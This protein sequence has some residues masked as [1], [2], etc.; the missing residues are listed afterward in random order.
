VSTPAAALAEALA[1]QAEVTAV[2]GGQ[3]WTMVPEPAP[4]SLRDPVTGEPGLQLEFRSALGAVLAAEHRTAT[5]LTWWEGVPPGVGWGEHGSVVLRAWFRP[6][7]PGRHIIG[8]A[9]V[10]RL[11]L[12]ADGKVVADD[13]TRVPD[14][15]VEA[16]TRPGEVRAEVTLE[17]GREVFLRLEFWPAA[18]GAG[19]LSLRL[20]AVPAED[21]EAM[22]VAAV[23]AAARADTAV[24]V[25]GSAEL[26]ESEGF[27][28][29]TLAL[30]GLQDDLI[31]RV[32]AVNP[33]TIVVVN[34]GMPVLMPWAAHVAAVLQAW[35]PGQAM[36]EALADV[37]LGRAEPGGRLP[38]TMPVSEAD[39]PVLH[40]VPKDGVLSYDEGLFIGYRGYQASGTSPLFPFGHGLGY[41]TWAYESAFAVTAEV[42]PGADLELRATVRNTGSR[43]G[44]EVVQAYLAGPPADPARP[45]RVLAAF[46]AAT[47][48]PGECAEVSLLVPASAFARYDRDAAGWVWPGGQFTVHIGRSSED[49]R[50]AVPVVCP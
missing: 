1:G 20:G 3:T 32:A 41:T 4:G 11:S 13:S 25:V 10:G 21:D 19:P 44:R 29:A 40:A 16:M 8:A 2:P 50:L 15:P 47:A 42:A 39:A 9:G 31:R 48:A 35:L 46:G 6:D 28:R 38:V 5:A 43:P 22:L 27:D 37:L 14:D 12:T 33:D 17:A 7:R 26:T 36:G 18:G 30:P 34:S 49:L 45:A 23:R 24:V